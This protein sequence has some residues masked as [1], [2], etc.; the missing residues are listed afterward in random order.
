[1]YK[2]YIWKSMGDTVN[3]QYDYNATAVTSIKYN[4]K[5]AISDVYKTAAICATLPENIL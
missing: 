1:M 5:I 4:Y 3:Y 2:G